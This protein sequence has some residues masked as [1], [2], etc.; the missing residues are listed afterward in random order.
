MKEKSQKNSI[1]EDK[2]INHILI[3]SISFY[4]NF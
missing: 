1:L 3:T 4:E 2:F